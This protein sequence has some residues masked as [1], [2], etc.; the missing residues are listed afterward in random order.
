[1]AYIVKVTFR[2]ERDF[3]SIFTEINAEHS[4]TALKWYQGFKKAILSLEVQPN[5]CPQTPESSL[6]RHLL[7]GREPYIYR[8]IYRVLEKQ[9]EVEV[10]HIRHGARDRLKKSS[11]MRGSRTKFLKAMGKVAKKRPAGQD[12]V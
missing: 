4:L 12:R 11:A 9:K 5:R 3:L 1:M 10:L 6:Y 7:Y 2:A 8:A